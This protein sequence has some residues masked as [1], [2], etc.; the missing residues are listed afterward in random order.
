MSDQKQNSIETKAVSYSTN[1]IPQSL[2][3]S[4]LNSN[5]NDNSK[6]NIID[7]DIKSNGKQMNGVTSSNGK[8]QRS[9]TIAVP[10]HN[11]N[12]NST[13]SELVAVVIDG[14]HMFRCDS[15]Y[16]VAVKNLVLNLK[17]KNLI[18]IFFNLRK[19]THRGLLSTL[20]MKKKDNKE[21][22]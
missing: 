15:T 16:A 10:N 14:E 21:R 2:S 11:N 19:S 4:K 7:M 3:D 22:T 18:T 1:T 9:N 13:S 12:N 20:G 5:G 8:P 17:K 6:T